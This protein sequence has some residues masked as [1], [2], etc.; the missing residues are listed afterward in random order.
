MVHNVLDFRIK[1]V[2]ILK[3]KF[4]KVNFV[5]RIQFYKTSANFIKNSAHNDLGN[6]F[7]YIVCVFYQ[8]F[9]LEK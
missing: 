8:S 3:N 7:F 9:Y 5:I 6:K 2:D 1:I 4:Q